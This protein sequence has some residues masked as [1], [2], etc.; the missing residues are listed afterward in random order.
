MY[1]I[2]CIHYSV[3]GHLGSFQ[4]L[5]IINKAAMNIVKHVSLLQVGI[6]SGYMPRRGIYG[7]SS[8]TMSN[9]LRNQ[10]TDFQC[11]C[12]RMKFYKQWRSFPLSPHPCQHLMSPDFFL[13]DI[14]LFIFQ[15]L[16]QKFPIPSPHHALLPTHFHL[17]ALAF[18][19]TG[20]YKGCK[21]KG[22]LFPMM[23]N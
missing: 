19:C 21:T 16:F 20:A 18:P 10:K 14:F 5:A 13:L 6:S 15:I 2:F 9:Y 3:E 23:A 22:P 7:S 8:G 11:V 4:H 17:L 12:T 1:H